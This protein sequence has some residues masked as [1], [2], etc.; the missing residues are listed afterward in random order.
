MRRT[1]LGLVAFLVIAASGLAQRVVDVNGQHIQ[2]YPPNSHVP[3]WAGGGGGGGSLLKF[4]GGPVMTG[5]VNIVAIFWGSE[6]SGSSVATNLTDFFQHFG[7]TGE[8][9][10]ISQYYDSNGVFISGG[11][12]Y[13]LATTSWTDTSNPPINVTDADVQAEVTKY[14]TGHGGAR[15][16]TIYEV[17][18]P[19]GSYASFSTYTSCGGPN[20][21]FCAYHSNFSTGPRGGGI[22][23]KY[24]SMPYPSCSGCQWTGWTDAENFNHFACHETREAV[25]DPDGT[26][27][28][29]PRGNEADDKCAWSPAPFID[30]GFGYQDEWSNAV[31][32]CVQKMP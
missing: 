7:G 8:Y 21:Y 19:S 3:E 27:W 18:L 30:G 24:S 11:S 26:A 12:G 22:D 31:R 28:Y 29:D 14:Y 23:V 20:L 4:H 13:T 15:S 5:N 25:T 1:L 9:N 16:D 2:F 6:W 32:G 10:V 17:F